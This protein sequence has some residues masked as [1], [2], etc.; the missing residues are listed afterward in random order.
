MDTIASATTIAPVSSAPAVSI[1][2]PCYNG[3]R[4]LDGLMAS[5][6]RQT[7]R[8][9]EVVIVDDGSTDEATVR[10]LAT[11]QDT[12]QGF[13][14]GSGARHPPA[15]PRGVRGAQYR[16]PRSRCRFPFHARLRRYGRAEFLAEVVPALRTAPPDV[17]VAVAHM[18]LIGAETGVARRYF[19]RFDLLFT[20]T[21]SPGIVVRKECWRAA[22]GY[23]ETMRDG[24]EDWDFS[25]RLAE[26]GYR[27]IEI[28]KP[29]YIYHVASDDQIA[30]PIV[31]RP[32]AAPLRQTVATDPQPAC[33]KLWPDRYRA[34][35]VVEAPRPWR[36]RRVVE[37]ACGLP[38]R[39][40][41]ARYRVQPA[42]RGPATAT[43]ARPQ[44]I[45]FGFA[46]SRPR[47]QASLR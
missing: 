12:S 22:G 38:R 35:V 46:A 3:G 6:A 20:N 1:V 2:V 15:Q 19:N 45:A 8:D 40:D 17:G 9:F 39:A 33:A 11:L 25:L 37:G 42:I 24:Y 5:L 21:L 14:A 44:L 41:A 7:F 26:A 10:K 47:G 34:A 4:F 16:R 43:H 28:A 31:G 23:D 32:Y 18:R 13:L 27:A 36:P 29:L 30:Q